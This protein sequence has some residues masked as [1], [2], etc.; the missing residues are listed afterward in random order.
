MIYSS[1]KIFHNIS[2]ST[3]CKERWQVGKRLGTFARI[4]NVS[5]APPL[6]SNRR[7]SENRHFGVYAYL[8]KIEAFRENKH[9]HIFN[10]GVYAYLRALFS[11]NNEEFG[12]N[13]IFGQPPRHQMVLY[14]FFLSLIFFNFRFFRFL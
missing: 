14:S 3:N 12:Q 8:F 10:I 5:F 1:H 6:Y 13:G 7:L 2:K 9:R 11:L 4:L